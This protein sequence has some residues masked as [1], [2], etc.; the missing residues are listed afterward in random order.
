M[1]TGRGGSLKL[2]DSWRRGHP[3]AGGA[4]GIM[5][6]EMGVAGEQVGRDGGSGGVGQESGID[7]EGIGGNLHRHTSLPGRCECLNTFLNAS[8]TNKLE[9]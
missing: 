7:G 5:G 6:D 8:A 2:K 9:T 4:V 3:S 1:G